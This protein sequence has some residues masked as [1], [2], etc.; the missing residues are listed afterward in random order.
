MASLVGLTAKRE[1]VQLPLSSWGSG[2]RRLSALAIAE[3]IQ[4]GNPIT[5][6]DEVGPGLEPFRQRILMARLQGTTSQAF[7]TTHSP[8]VISP[9]AKASL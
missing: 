4:G 5:V 7:I 9:A 6:V 3:Q 2:T 8:A 1:T